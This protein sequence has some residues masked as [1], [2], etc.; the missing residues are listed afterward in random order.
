MFPGDFAASRPDHP[1][2]IM[3]TSGQVTT[4]AELDAEAN[5]L[6]HLLRASGLQ[7]GDHV[8][9]C[10]E[11]GPR[12]L[13]VAWGCHYAGL[14]YTAMSSR[15][16]TEEMAYILDDCGARAFITSRHKAEQASQLVDQMPEVRVR[17]MVD[18]TVDDFEPYEASV[19]EHPT[20]PLHGDRP[21]GQDMLYSSG[22][23]GR[24]KGVK[25]PLPDARL[26]EAS[27]GVTATGQLLFGANE[28]T[29]YLS[30]APLNHAAPL[31]FGRAVM[32][33]CG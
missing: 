8:A 26:G 1:A 27:D 5:Q 13:P 14:Y 22:T 24:P 20:T 28:A 18:G 12:F 2:V 25:V 7:P 31:R 30:P 29:R 4:Y 23:T 15:L 6:S 10:L 21:E 17:V 3:A 11:N 19:A 33:A 9:F 16:T 32:K